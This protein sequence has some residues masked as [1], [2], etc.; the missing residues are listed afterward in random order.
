M[1]FDLSNKEVSTPRRPV[2]LC[3]FTFPDGSVWYAA[4]I[5][6]TH[7][8]HSY[9]AAIVEP[10]LDR[11]AALAA[12]GFDF[13]PSVTLTIADADGSIYTVWERGSL[14]GFK[15]AT[16]LL[17]LVLYDVAA[18][19][20]STN[21][22]VP[23][24][25]TCDQPAVDDQGLTVAASN[26]LNLT[27][28]Q[29]PTT[30]ISVR[31]PWINPKTTQQRSEAS[32]A[33]SRFFRCGE[34]RDLVTAP[35]CSQTTQ[36]C[37]QPTHF[38]GSG[39]QTAKQ[40]E[41]REYISGNKVAWNNPDTSG[42]LK[43]YWP[44]WLGGAAWVDI[45]VLNQ[46]ADGNYT[47]GEAGVGVGPVDVL[48]VIVN[49]IELSQG[50]SGDYRWHFVNN[51]ARA[52]A[53]NTDTGYTDGDVYGNETVI[54]FLAPH[55][56]IDPNSTASVRVL[57][58]KSTSSASISIVSAAATAGLIRVE[59]GRLM[60][61]GDPGDGTLVTITGNTWAAVNG[62][63]ILRYLDLPYDHAYLEGTNTT[64]SGTGGSLHYNS[65]TLGSGGSVPTTWVIQEALRAPGRFSDADFGST[66]TGAADICEEIISF[67]DGDGVASSQSRF[68]SS[69]A[70]KDRRSVADVVRGLRQS[71]GSFLYCGQDG[72]LEIFV[73]GP[74]A[75]QQ[76]SAVSGSNYATPIS[77]TLRDGTTAANGYAAY[78]FD[79][80]NSWDLKRTAQANSST[81]NK[82]VFPF[83]DPANDW[84]V[85]TFAEFDPEDVSRLEQET[86]GG[87]QVQPEG[88]ASY[89]FAYRCARLGLSKLLRGNPAG[90]TRGTDWW[91]WQ[92]S[93]RACEVQIGH[94]VLLNETRY[95][96]TNQL[97]R[98]TGIKPSRN[99]ETVT[100]VGHHH[101][102]DWYFD[103]PSTFADPERAFYH[104]VPPPPDGSSRTITT[105]GAQL[106]SDNLDL[107]DT[108]GISGSTTTLSA[109]MTDTTTATFTVTSGASIVDGTYLRIGTETLGPASGGG[110][111][112][113]TAP[114]GALGTVAATHSNGSTVYIGGALTF[115]L[116]AIADWP[117]QSLI[118][119][120]LTDDLN[121]VKILMAGGDT[122][123]GGVTQW[124]LPS[125]TASEGT[126]S[127]RSPDATGTEWVI[128]T[129]A[130]SA[131]P[132]GP[133]G[134]AG[135]GT[136]APNVTATATVFYQPY[137][138]LYQFGFHG[139][140]TLPTSDPDY[141]HLDRIDVIAVDAAGNG[142]LLCAFL[143]WSGSTIAYSGLV[144]SLDTSQNWSV[145]FQVYNEQGAPST[146]PYAVSGIAVQA[147]A[148]SSVSASK[149]SG[150]EYQDDVQG[151][152]A[153][154]RVVPVVA[155][156]RFPQ[157]VD[158]WLDKSDGLG[159][160]NQGWWTLSTVG[161]AINI[162]AYVPLDPA[163][164][165]WKVAAFAGTINLTLGPPAGFVQNTFTFPAAAACIAN[166]VSNAQFVP[167]GSGNTINYIQHSVGIWEWVFAEIQWTQPSLS[168][169]PNYWFSF[170]TVQ[171]GYTDGGGTWHPAPDREGVDEKPGLY[172]GRWIT[173][174]GHIQGMSSVLGSTVSLVGDLDLSWTFPPE[175]NPDGTANLYREFRFWIYDASVRNRSS[176]SPASFTLQ[177]TA[178]GG[179]DHGTLTPV[180]QPGALDLTN[181]NAH[182]L[183]RGLASGSGGKPETKLSGGLAFDGSGNNIADLGY[184]MHL[185]GSGKIALS[186]LPA[187]FGLPSLPNSAYPAGSVILNTADNKIYRNPT[188]SAWLVSHSPVDLVAGAIATG[189]TLAAAQVSAGTLNVGVAYAGV[190]NAS[191]VNA[192]TFTGFTFVGCTASLNLNGITTSINNN[193]DPGSA[194]PAGVEVK[195][196]FTGNYSV[197]TALGLF[198]CDSSN[199]VRAYLQLVGTGASCRIADT[200]S[201]AMVQ[202]QIFA[203]HGRILIDGQKVLGP[204]VASTPSTLADVIS[205]LQT[206]GLCN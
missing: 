185:D 24:I 188:G 84:A 56:T 164:T 145:V 32:S 206:Q 103:T 41:G 140:I 83:L 121:Y 104:F 177:T 65:A 39:W 43:Q 123:P 33:D 77:S 71:I 128:L 141:S 60:G 157:P 82:V 142:F 97:V 42:K 49:N 163:Q 116:L 57:G 114:R 107:F 47:R 78:R 89:N 182:T 154:V 143:T 26:K 85:S 19:E 23:F 14:K 27:Q 34:T 101:E 40:G 35:P 8:G 90:D 202:M 80:S 179:A 160:Q 199:T 168:A 187:V 76:P 20:R 146:S 132:P 130:G 28:L 161:Q 203:G 112:T 170:I 67:T 46:W 173:D 115:D 6:L 94:L 93:F 29:L 102:D 62:S 61:T 10:N 1:S 111:T 38:G 4:T 3:D 74:L 73:E 22:L 105:S 44:Q 183:G 147:S 122:F 2:L 59:F 81:P 17:R 91:E 64:G 125:N 9:V 167:D 175:L 136:P 72:K 70:L 75:E 106:D 95:G 36:T 198:V 204:R 158:I 162:D 180:T 117:D 68:G 186:N 196:N 108:S 7:A 51:G 11:M 52:G 37:T 190:I 153:T 31:C 69:V 92:T 195:D 149:V 194:L 139:T 113:I 155:G 86:A 109:A 127:L 63:F 12:Q 110:T 135:V 192:G 48:R 156:A 15:G 137:G 5:A 87:L 100:L 54:Q 45:P 150:S 58:R 171:K 200:A 55:S 138:N 151:L 181:T 25:G 66:W 88:I 133:P 174:S 176:A 50:M 148:I 16:L 119:R 205:I 120:K 99:Y 131:G 201:S 191:Q 152:H 18:D 13:V 134:A 172:S 126:I 30:A 169:D 189:V 79:E 129:S 197:Q 118:L 21:S 184:T 159:W 165:A 193:T 96:L 166:G 178:W 98:V 144:G 53:H 124:I